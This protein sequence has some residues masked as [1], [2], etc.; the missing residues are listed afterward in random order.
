MTKQRESGKDKVGLG[1]FP[2][3][4]ALSLVPCPLSL[5]RVRAVS[6]KLSAVGV[7]A[8]V[9]FMGCPQGGSTAQSA[10]LPDQVIEGFTLHESS[11]GE[12]L[13]TLEAETAYV[14]EAD[15][16][17]ESNVSV[18]KPKVLFYDS[19][20]RVN[21]TLWADRGAIRSRSED[22]VAYGNVVVKTNDSTSLW[23]DSLAWSNTQ[24]V[25]RTD[26]DVVVETPKGRVAGRGLESDAALERIQILS[27]VQGS[28]Q[29]EFDAPGAGQDTQ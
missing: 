15:E 6:C 24:R 21:A 5:R 27:P 4:L 28:S 2:F 14:Y 20:G 23:T 25:V 26:A 11:S 10:K 22:L 9:L 12:R 29:Y 18:V 1:T 3:V 13:Y 7:L 19:E 17:H 16:S 8:L